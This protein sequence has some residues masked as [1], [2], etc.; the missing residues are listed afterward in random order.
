MVGVPPHYRVA[1]ILPMMVT[2]IKIYSIHFDVN[3]APNSLRVCTAN[4]DGS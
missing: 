3:L 1:R 2:A 4:F